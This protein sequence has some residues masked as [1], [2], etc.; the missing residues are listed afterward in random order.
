MSLSYVMVS[1]PENLPAEKLTISVRN[2]GI[3]QEI[4]ALSPYWVEKKDLILYEGPPT[5]SNLIPGSVGAWKSKISIYLEN[6][7]WLL[8]LEHHRF[9]S[10]V[11]HH[12]QC[13]DMI[14]SFLQEARPPYMTPY[15]MKDVRSLY[16]EIRRLVL[17][18]F[19]RLVTNKESKTQWLSKE[20][21]S[22]QF[23]DNFIFTIPLLF[24]IC[25][26]YGCDNNRHVSRMLEA[27]FTL[28]PKYMD[29]TAGA[30]RFAHEAFKFI[31]LQVNNNYDCEEPPNL[32]ATYKGFGEIR[33][34]S[35][36][37]D[38]EKLTLDILKDL[39]IHMLDTAMTLR[40]FLEVYPKS[41]DIFRNTNF[42]LSIAQ[43]YEYGIP[44]LYEKLEE[45]GDQSSSSYTELEGYIDLSR[46]ELIDVIREIL[47]VYKSYILSGEG[48]ISQN[49]EAYLSVMM[50]ALSEN[51]LIRDY[52]VCY[53]V[54]DDLEMLKQAFPDID[55]VKTDF[56][57]QAIY[58][59]LHED[60][61]EP[62]HI[63]KQEHRQLN[64]H[65]ETRDSR[66]G[67]STDN[68]LPDE[69]KEQSLI[70][71]V[72]DILPH[73]GDGFILKC[74]KYY[75]FN[76]ERVISSVLEG[77]LA[78]S[79]RGIDQSLP[80]VPE[81]PLDKK[82]LETGVERLN[83]FDGDQF[84]LMTRDDVDLSKIHLGKRKSKYKDLKDMLNDNKDVKSR[85]DIYSK[86]N[87]VCDDVAM[88]SD[89][90]DDTYDSDGIV[91]NTDLTDDVRRP[92][93][94]PRVLQS[95]A[96]NDEVSE[97][98]ESEEE[99]PSGSQ[100]RREFCVDPALLRAR[101]EATRQPRRPDHRPPPQKSIDVVGK[102]KGHG[103]EKEVLHNRDKKEKHKSSRANHNRRQGAQ[104]K[105][106]QGMMPS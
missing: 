1:N 39:I 19:S 5:G 27:V 21:M 80:V 60:Q 75:D 31:I 81:D 88:Y 25:L 59:N 90:Y 43:L 68:E 85:A 9:W 14:I 11:L 44:H 35:D 105:R 94:T 76:V 16:E 62:T 33:R 23:F 98:S 87:L 74:L 6:L 93:V 71:E 20:F 91:P 24:D 38:H 96:K 18:V 92:F 36:S 70:S 64:G 97:E 46:S 84:D 7:K 4:K 57:L 106:S 69:I 28:Q 95:R 86:Y 2:G 73:L 48:N 50:Q 8:S 65:V 56:I 13:M 53:P 41:A 55:T 12:S 22:K 54:H 58:S 101:R 63:E 45:I 79:L 42:V 3:L 67:P 100:Q 103:Q 51:L 89:E 30:L 77:N 99:R 34:P 17:V 66:P 82:F 61:P 15:E 47:A 78:E 72:K 40:I 52:H 32:P 10:T 104:W 29:E 49:M 26:I 83:V 37:K 102:P